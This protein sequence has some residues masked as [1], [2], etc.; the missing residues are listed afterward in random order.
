MPKKSQ[1]N[2]GVWELY[3][4]AVLVHF[5]Q[6]YVIEMTR[7]IIKNRFFNAYKLVGAHLLFSPMT[8]YQARKFRMQ[9]KSRKKKYSTVNRK[10]CPISYLNEYKINI[11]NDTK[12]N[13]T[14]SHHYW[15]I[16]LFYDIIT[17]YNSQLMV[18]KCR[19]KKTHF[20]IWPIAFRCHSH[21]RWCVW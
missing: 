19:E 8:V 10:N 18:W 11:C 5:T 2:C 12:K 15:M 4:K 17:N 16:Y 14:K 3:A 9:N 13:C 21:C 6:F 7:W 20:N 1:L